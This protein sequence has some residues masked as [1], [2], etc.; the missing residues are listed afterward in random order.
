[1]HDEHA[2]LHD[3]CTLFL[4]VVKMTLYK[5]NIVSKNDKNSDPC[6]SLEDFAMGKSI[7]CYNLQDLI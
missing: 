4:I 5:C 2:C 6:A 7:S 1:M 3:T